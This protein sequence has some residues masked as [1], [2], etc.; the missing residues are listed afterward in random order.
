MGQAIR[1][2][3]FTSCLIPASFIL[4]QTTPISIGSALPKDPAMLLAMARSQNG[5]DAPG[6]QPWH[7]KASYQT[8]DDNGQ[9]KDTG[10]F[11]EWWAGP[12]QYNAAIQAKTSHRLNM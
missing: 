7:L 3:L 4:S 11:E 5:L 12:K 10:V 2:L 6:L 1:T 9:P 8:F